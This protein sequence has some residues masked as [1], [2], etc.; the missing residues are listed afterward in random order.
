MRGEETEGGGKE[1]GT[2]GE[3]GRREGGGGGERGG[4]GGGEGGGGGGGREVRTAP[5]INY[6]ALVSSS[7]LR[8][9][10]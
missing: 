1:R 5:R 3:G 8:S 6:S 4:G 10:L 2:E 9:D 7:L